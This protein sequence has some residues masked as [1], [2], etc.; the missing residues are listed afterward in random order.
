MTINALIIRKDSGAGPSD[1]K[2]IRYR[3]KYLDTELRRGRVG[4]SGSGTNLV[5]EPSESA[6]LQ[7]HPRRFNPLITKDGQTL[8]VFEMS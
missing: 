1:T 5:K 4:D 6:F 7:T 2:L 3:I 8:L